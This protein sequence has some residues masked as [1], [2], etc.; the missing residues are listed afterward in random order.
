LTSAT[1]SHA[2]NAVPARV[3]TTHPGAS[4]RRP[5]MKVSGRP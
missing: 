4:G 3:M 2:P 1:L 5:R